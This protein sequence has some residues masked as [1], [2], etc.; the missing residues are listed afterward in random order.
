[1]LDDRNLPA[2]YAASMFERPPR[3]RVSTVAMLLFAIGLLA[4]A[5]VFV[6][7]ALGHRD[8]P[9]WLSTASL[10]LPVGLAIGIGRTVLLARRTAQP[11]GDER[12]NDP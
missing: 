3:D 8:L 5:A 6:L 10:L 9:V 11:G 4:L 1:M 12:G 2:E 7:F